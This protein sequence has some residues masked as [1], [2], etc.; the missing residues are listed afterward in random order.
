[1]FSVSAQQKLMSPNEFLGYELGER[2]T[3][4]YKVM[5]YLKH[6]DDAMP[7][8]EFKQYGE[9]YEHRPLT[10]VVITSPENFKNL[11]NIRLDN[12]KRTGLIE[13]TASHDKKSIV[14]LSYNVHGNEASSME[15]A[16]W[17]LYELANVN[18]PKTQE[19]LKNTVVIMDPFL[20]HKRQL[21]LLQLQPLRI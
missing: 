19:W 4:H 1:M 12:L 21:P 11:E 18:N 8:I 5:E 7:N 14:W 3:R 17:T 16:M 6:V 10:F 20:K 15:A 13:G 2:F 9:T